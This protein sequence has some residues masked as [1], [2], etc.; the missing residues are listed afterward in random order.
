[1]TGNFGR[2]KGE[3][4]PPKEYGKAYWQFYSGEPGSS[5]ALLRALWFAAR[6]SPGYANAEGLCEEL[7][8]EPLRKGNYDHFRKISDHLANKEL[9]SSRPPETYKLNQIEHCI[10]CAFEGFRRQPLV[11][12]KWPRWDDVKKRALQI[13]AANRLIKKGVFSTQCH[14]DNLNKEQE[15]ELAR[16]KSASPRVANWPA[17]RRTCGLEWLLD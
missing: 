8:L 17:V 3:L 16:E 2:S 12:G 5:Q 15:Q 14:I 13:R 4:E 10:F 6:V 7:F 11:P 9:N 1:M